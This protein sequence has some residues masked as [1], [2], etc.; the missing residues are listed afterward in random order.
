[1]GVPIVPLNMLRSA[2]SSRDWPVLSS[3]E[4]EANML[5]VV[6]DDATDLGRE[7]GLAGFDPEGECLTD[8]GVYPHPWIVDAYRVAWRRAATEVLSHAR[9]TDSFARR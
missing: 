2:R 6:M 5:R 7:N 9:T 3:S 1:M 8:D 4:R